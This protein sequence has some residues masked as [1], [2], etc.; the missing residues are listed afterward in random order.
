M[1]R[2]MRAGCGVTMTGRLGAG[3]GLLRLT[4]P[5]E[6]LGAAIVRARLESSPVGHVVVLRGSR[7]LRTHVDVWGVAVSAPAAALK[8]ALDPTGILNAGR[9]PM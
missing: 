5:D 2:A 4:G 8:R 9:G 6:A 3:S 7:A 1:V